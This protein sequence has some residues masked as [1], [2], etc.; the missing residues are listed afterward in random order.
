VRPGD[1]AWRK[2]IG[3][4]ASGVFLGVLAG[5]ADRI[6]ASEA[7]QI[8]LGDPAASPIELSARSWR[9]VISRTFADFTRD[10]ITA[11]AAGVT[12]FSLLALFPALGVFVSLYGLFADVGDASRQISTLQG[13]LPS[14][15]VVVIGDQMKRLAAT[16][17]GR[18]GVTLLISL[19]LSTWSSNAAVKALIGGLNIAY[20][21]REHRNFFVLN[22]T[23]LAFTVGATL[24]SVVSVAAV[25]V[26]PEVLARAHLSN[27]AWLGFIRWPVLL[28]LVT[29]LL[30]LLY[31]FGPCRP[32][33][34][35]RWITPGGL[36]GALGWLIMSL[37]F[38]FYVAHF[39]HYD[40]TYGSLGAVVG[41]MTWIWLSI[42]VV[43]FGAEL[44]SELEAQT[45]H[46]PAQAGVGADGV[47][48]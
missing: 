30:S 6:L 45:G 4:L 16:D 14:G 42:I 3:L 46:R 44:N 48:R 13:V 40:R 34:R 31:R 10:Q 1:N 27:M 15:A 43:L 8:P 47:I 29:G 17:H 23:S 2:S 20:E 33:A 9:D 22:A 21:E 38:S 35:W 32:M 24:L 36:V 11:V 37:G 26:G 18:L 5:Y 7:K 28:I 25:A 12:F 39:G 19:V 41:F